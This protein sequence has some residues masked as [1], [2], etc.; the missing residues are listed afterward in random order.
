MEK[1]SL[2]IVA[3]AIAGCQTEN[4]PKH[5]SEN[6]ST[7][8]TRSRSI[9]IVRAGSGKSIKQFIKAPTSYEWSTEEESSFGQFLQEIEVLE[10][11]SDILDFRGSPISNQ[12]EHVAIL[13]YD[14]GTRD[15]QQCADAVIRLRAEYLFKEKKYDDI[16]FHFTSGDIFTW[17]DYVKGI[18]PVVS[19]NQVSFQNI[20]A[21]NDGYD[22][23]RK[24][25]D[26][27]FT[28][29]GTISLHRETAPVDNN[30]KIKAGD[31]IIK[32]GS[33]G[34]AIIIVGVAKNNQ[35]EKVFLLAEGY[36]PAQSIHVIKNTN[37]PDLSPWYKLEINAPSTSTARY[38]FSPTNIRSF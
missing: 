33:P 1:L 15:L 16:K 14:I 20:G 31:I 4:R 27:V 28:Y 37:N 11:G 32:P 12:S 6:H 34:H 36:T 7:E 8:N 2:F 10:A 25:L 17:N 3:V 18:R 5:E 30:S 26:I 21:P 38:T 9:E 13:N 19:G 22:G 23:F 24:Y 35:G 29:A